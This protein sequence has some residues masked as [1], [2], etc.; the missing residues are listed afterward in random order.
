MPVF[1][2]SYDYY[3]EIRDD[4]GA[5]IAVY[6]DGVSLQYV[7][8]VNDIGQ[9]VWTVPNDHAVLD[10]L[11]DN[12]YFRIFL[13]YRLLDPNEYI[14]WNEDFIGVYVD[15]RSVT[16]QFGNIYHILQIPHANEVL[17]R[18]IVGSYSGED[19]DSE[20][21]DDPIGTIMYRLVA[22][23]ILDLAGSR[24]RN[25]DEIPSIGTD[26]TILG[27]GSSIDY[28]CAW[29]PV[30][31][32]LR[33]LS[34]LSGIDFNVEWDNSGGV[35]LRVNFYSDQI[36]TDKSS[37]IIFDIGLGNL[38]QAS[39]GSTKAQEKTVAIVGGQGTD[40][41]RDIS[42]R[43]G[44]NYSTTHSR[45]MFVDA[46]DKTTSELADFG[47]LQLS[48]SEAVVTID[49]EI[50]QTSGYLYKRDYDFGDLV[51][52][53]FLDTIQIREITEVAVTFTQDGDV[54]IDIGFEEVSA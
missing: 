5:L 22:G 18:S 3:I 14:T 35:I 1:T 29:R 24:V 12:L 34:D 6:N 47:D 27:V 38:R 16:D 54:S 53:R 45:E 28:A 46:R 11:E 4:T 8:K 33:E 51:S 41:S 39:L 44:A 2:D 20:F 30:Y 43:T 36:G 7:K 42:V 23:H 9:M 32:V 25:V 52:V 17:T 10:L 40:D 49:A 15:K 50:L 13:G 37:D 48:Y 31:E 26:A 21:T 19:Q